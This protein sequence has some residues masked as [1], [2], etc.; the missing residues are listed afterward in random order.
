M[1]PEQK[2]SARLAVFAFLNHRM[3][4]RFKRSVGVICIVL[5]LAVVVASGISTYHARKSR[6]VNLRMENIGEL[7]TQ[8]AYYTN[9]QVIRNDRK[10][11]DITVPF[12]QNQYIYSYDG[13]IKAGIDFSKLRAI[14]N[15]ID[16]TIT[17]TIPHAFI[18]SNEVD[19]N[20]LEIYDE[21]RN[22]FT[23]L[24]LEDIQASRELMKEE[25]AETAMQ[26]GILEAAETNA[27]QLIECFLKT[28]P[29]N[30]QYTILFVNE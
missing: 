29:A 6:T 11:F 28:D 19:E 12:T 1:M 8:A 13:I 17:V 27:K 22:I 7:S 25:A 18:T 4:R 24:K 30:E 15:E 26:N 21:S 20:S 9:V 10:V 2:K 23:P 3:S 14:A 5:G 16:K